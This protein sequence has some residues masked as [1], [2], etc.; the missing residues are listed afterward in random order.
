MCYERGQYWGERLRQ[1]WE[2]E[3]TKWRGCREVNWTDRYVEK[4]MENCYFVS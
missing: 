4:P 3:E 2:G 1:G